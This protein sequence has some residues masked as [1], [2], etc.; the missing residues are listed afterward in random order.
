MSKA[1]GK[2][3]S[4]NSPKRKG[5]S[6]ALNTPD[7]LAE[8][9][10]QIRQILP[11]VFTEGKID[12]EKLLA[13]LGDAADEK[14][15]RYAFTWA[16]KRQSILELQKPTWGTLVPAKNESVNF[17]T[18]QNIF[19]EGENLEVLKLL[20]KAYF[21][22]VKMIYIDPPYNTGGDFVYPDNFADPKDAYL[23]VTGQKDAEGNLLTSNPESSGRYHSAW[24]SMMYPRLF[25]ARQLLRDDGVIFVSIDDHEVHNL[26]MLM[27]EIF[28]EEN[29]V[30]TVIWQKVYAPKNTARHFSEDHDF[31]LVFA[32][33]AEIWMPSLLPR[34]DAANARYDNRDKDPRGAW[35]ASDMTAR[36]Y[37][38]QG[39][40]EVT[41]PTGKK[42]KSGLGRYWRCSYENFLKL[43]KD[44]RIWWGETGDNMP[45]GK[46]FI[47]EVKQGIVPQTLWHYKDVGHTQ[48]AKKELLKFV[49]FE[50]TDNVIDSVKPP[51]LI[52]K[53][54]EIGTSNEDEDIV[55]DFF[56]GTGATAQAV[57]QQNAKD[58][59]RRKFV[60]VQMP[61][62]L[63][64]PENKLKSIADV[65]KNR[66]FNASKAVADKFKGELQLGEDA[67]LDFGFSV[68][69]LTPSNFKPWVNE[70]DASPETLAKA[71]ELFNDPLAD[72]W[73]PENVIYEVA[74][75]EGFTLALRV[76]KI[77]SLKA[78]K[79][80]QVTD[81]EKG[82]SFRI[83][84]DDD[85]KA[86]TVKELSLK[87]DD[88][89]ICR[90]V[91]IDDKTAANLALQC[92]LKTI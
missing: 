48:D 17:D 13:A 43:D 22:R 66:M 21:G 47:S 62:P 55:V 9:A 46:R 26:R 19:I 71:M 89:F 60:L 85:L 92:R 40:Y 59:G 72:G 56:A 27:N 57:F 81:A 6:V 61:T 68:F 23:R 67:P 25:L 65:T 5:E 86:V 74:V 84:L 44:N 7:F 10:E 14:P 91:A 28:G 33:N 29:F 18:T 42:F 77:S 36:N 38:A 31:I 35:K 83:C 2:K 16:G 78:N 70:P 49:S 87:K 53:M 8:Q 32:K 50:N 52:Q 51:T 1:T 64:K 79:I 12:V 34:T 11:H 30:A 24:L 45:A 20:Y 76:E 80:F 58:G 88:L 41:G 75:K 90:D 39:T 37:Y 69:K 3:S 4:R 82:Q 73:K 54:L 63:D 15:E